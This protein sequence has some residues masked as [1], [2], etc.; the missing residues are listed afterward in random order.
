MD[1]PPPFDWESVFKNCLSLFADRL[2]LF[3]FRYAV[4]GMRYAVP[5]PFERES[6]FRLSRESRTADRYSFLF[7]SGSI[8]EM[9]SNRFAVR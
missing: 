8:G 6:V 9:G 2:P 4:G 1:I 3:A 5:I 7:P